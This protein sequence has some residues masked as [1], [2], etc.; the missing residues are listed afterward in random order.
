MQV[1]ISAGVQCGTLTALVAVNHH[2]HHL[3]IGMW[4]IPPHATEEGMVMF[5]RF[6]AVAF[7]GMFAAGMAHAQA[8]AGMSTNGATTPSASSCEAKAIGKDGKPLTGA[9]K[10]SFLKKCEAG[11]KKSSAAAECEGKAVGSNGK[12]L[13]GAAKTSFMKKCEANA[14]K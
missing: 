1:G 12:P 14:A 7:A 6:V 8:S 13:A 11:M 4:G 5:K 3:V 10:S 2:A 9:A